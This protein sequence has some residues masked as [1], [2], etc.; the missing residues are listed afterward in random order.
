MGCCRRVTARSHQ[1][2]DETDAGSAFLVRSAAH[3]REPSEPGKILRPSDACTASESEIQSAEDVESR[4]AKLPRHRVLRCCR[5]NSSGGPCGPDGRSARLAV[6][7]CSK[8]ALSRT[9][10]FWVTFFCACGIFVS[11]TTS[12]T[13]FGRS[14]SGSASGLSA[15][16]SLCPQA[17]KAQ[18]AM[19]NTPRRV[20]RRCNVLP[21][22]R[23]RKMRQ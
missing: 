10:T 11:V 3:P 19:S 14:A 8:S 12:I 16:L 4:I 18:R 2:A 9:I 7:I 6:V 23:F 5:R 1:R 20:S 22:K 21:P 17:A 15:G 13:Y